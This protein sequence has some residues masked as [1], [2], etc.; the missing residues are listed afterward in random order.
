MIIDPK[1]HIRCAICDAQFVYLNDDE[2]ILDEERAK[3][4]RMRVGEYVCH[5]CW[6]NKILADEYGRPI[7][8]TGHC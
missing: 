4:V 1:R 8:E 2:A 5:S 6:I 7:M 3:A